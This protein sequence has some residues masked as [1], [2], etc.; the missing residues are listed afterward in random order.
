MR[1]SEGAL[2]RLLGRTAEERRG[3]R[4]G[5]PDKVFGDII[6]GDFP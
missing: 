2:A 6:C 1:V 3:R 5:V 4:D